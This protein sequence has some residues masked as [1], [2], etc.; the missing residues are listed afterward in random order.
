MTAAEARW[1]DLNGC[2]KPLA[3]REV[4]A[5]IYEEGYTACRKG[6][7]VRARVTIGGPHDWVVDND[8][9]WAFF[10]AHRRR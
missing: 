2:R 9:M 8:A 5:K 6:A 4:S 7:D 3:R 10:A 1:A